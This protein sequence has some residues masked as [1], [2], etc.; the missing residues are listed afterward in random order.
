MFHPAFAQIL[1]SKSNEIIHA[2]NENKR[3]ELLE[4]ARR[5]DG[6]TAQVVIE[7]LLEKTSLQRRQSSLGT[8][9]IKALIANGAHYGAV[10]SNN[11]T[12]MQTLR[13]LNEAD[14]FNPRQH[15]NGLNGLHAAACRPDA[16][17]RDRF[18]FFVEHAG[19]DISMANQTEP[20]FGNTPL[21]TLLAN[22]RG[23]FAV[24]YLDLLKDKDIDLSIQDH[25]G[26]TPLFLA[27]M[28]MSLPAV[29]KILALRADGHEFDL[30]AKDVE[31]RTALHM[32]C[33]F[34]QTE[35]VKA[36]LDAGADPR[37]EDSEGN[38]ASDYIDMGAD[39][40]LRTANSISIKM[41]R[42]KNAHCNH[43]VTIDWQSPILLTDKG[44]ETKELLWA[45]SSRAE[46]EKY[47]GRWGQE[48]YRRVSALMAGAAGQEGTEILRRYTLTPSNRKLLGEHL[49]ALS[50][51]TLMKHCLDGKPA[52]KALVDE[53]L[54]EYETTPTL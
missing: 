42:D 51:V 26:K 23:D 28:T 30:D 15:R 10:L 16:D 2:L 5:L 31:G 12:S 29:E 52:S 20:E 39:K 21:H 11:Q 35:M 7:E 43:F 40:L 4:L 54:A 13:W 34:G 22:E 3:R 19:F 24:W 32:A 33:L 44:I 1:G 8:D 17:Q 27:A 50:G 6:I 38:S 48:N 9:M 25:Q 18:R 36:L 49:A 53:K 46:I 47:V 37:V 14:D 45:E 41:F